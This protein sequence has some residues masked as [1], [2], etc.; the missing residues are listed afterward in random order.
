M[1]ARPVLDRPGSA[2]LLPE[3]AKV[4]IVDNS[5]SMGY[6]EDRGQRYDI[7]KSA[8]KKALEGFDG[9]VALIP[10]GRL[11][12]DQAFE[13]MQVEE[14]LN[15]ALYRHIQ[16]AHIAR[17]IMSAP[18]LAVTTEETIAFT[19]SLFDG[20][21]VNTLL[22]LN[23]GH[24]LGYITR[25][26][27]QRAIYHGLEEELVTEYMLTDLRTVKQDTPFS[28]IELL[29]IQRPQKIIPVLGDTDCA[30]GVITKNDILKVLQEQKLEK[31]V[32]QSDGEHVH[33]RNV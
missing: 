7:A 19:K 32:F 22:I 26:I 33:T 18:V 3:G 10:T 31:N 16:E 21:T 2:T 9:R 14:A 1:M 17:R 11:R 8:A 29:M 27:V 23:N 4:L 20:C 12:K 6:R 24:P 13:W 28:E 25:Q 5:L 30:V 15:K